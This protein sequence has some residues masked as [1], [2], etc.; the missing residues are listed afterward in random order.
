MY[1]DF[2]SEVDPKCILDL[3][4][5]ERIISFESKEE[6]LSKRTKSDRCRALL[7]QLFYC[8]H[9]KAFIVLREALKESYMWI[10]QRMDTGENT[11]EDKVNPNACN[12]TSI[13]LQL[14]NQEP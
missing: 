3:L 11:S 9:D 8:S 5:Q 2:V 7:D 14:F 4:I 12:V 6:V 13:Q 10:L 1:K